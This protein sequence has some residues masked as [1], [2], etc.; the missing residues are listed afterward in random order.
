MAVRPHAGTVEITPNGERRRILHRRG[1]LYNGSLHNNSKVPRVPKNGLT[2]FDAQG[3][4]LMA[5]PTGRVTLRFILPKTH[6]PKNTLF[7]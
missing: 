6:Y 5:L 1:A 2:Q 7:L 4:F 3:P